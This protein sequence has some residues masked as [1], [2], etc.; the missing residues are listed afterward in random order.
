MRRHDHRPDQD[1]KS[2]PAPRSHLGAVRSRS[3]R[4]WPS[5]CGTR[6]GCMLSIVLH[7]LAIVLVILLLPPSKEIAGSPRRLSQ[8]LRPSTIRRRFPR[9]RKKKRKRSRKRKIRKKR[10]E[11]SRTTEVT[12]VEEVSENE[13]FDDVSEVTVES[14]FDSNQWNSAVGLG[15]GAGGKYGGRGGGGKGGSAPRPASDDRAARSNSPSSG[16]RTTRTKTASGTP[17]TS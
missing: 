4:S 17:T 16:S 11:L 10:S 3:R 9:R 14:A 13:N 1:T 2:R 15:G 7:G 12:E 8:S 6:R 5:S